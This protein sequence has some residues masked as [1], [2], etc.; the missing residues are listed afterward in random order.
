MLI[1]ASDFTPTI[2]SYSGLIAQRHVTVL[3]PI[4][5]RDV[6]RAALFLEISSA[7]KTIVS[8]G[9]SNVSAVSNLRFGRWTV[10]IPFMIANSH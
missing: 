6:V 3:T 4:A 2:L 1:Q 5:G 9:T 10:G 8:N 7:D